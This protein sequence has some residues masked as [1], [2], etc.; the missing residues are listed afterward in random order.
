MEIS[1]HSL[2]GE[3]SAGSLCPS[4]MGGWYL[5]A[6]VC[7]AISGVRDSAL[8]HSWAALANLTYGTGYSVQAEVLPASTHPLPSSRQAEYLSEPGV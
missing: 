8:E 7:P 3:E 4:S 1:H 5:R 2:P 6:T